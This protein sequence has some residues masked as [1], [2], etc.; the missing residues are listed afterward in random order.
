MKFTVGFEETSYCINGSDLL[1]VVITSD[2]AADSTHQ[3][4][5]QL[6]LSSTHGS[7]SNVWSNVL[8]PNGS[9]T[10]TIPYV[11]PLAWANDARVVDMNGD[12]G[13]I[14]ATLSVVYVLTISPKQYTLNYSGYYGN[15]PATVDAS[16][17]PSVGTLSYTT[18]DGKVPESWDCLVQ[19]V[20][21]VR[22]SAPQAAGAYGSDIYY[23]YFNGGTAQMQNYADISLPTA[24]DVSVSV[25]VEDSRGRLSTADLYLSV[26]A[27]QTPSLTQVSSQRCSQDGTLAEEGEYYLA[28]GT[29]AGATLSGLNPITVTT[30]WKKVTE[31]SY[32]TALTI[33]PGQDAIVVANL[34]EGASYD[35]KYTIQDAF[36]TIELYDYLSSTV[37]LLHFLKGGSGIAVG[38]AAEQESL[39]DVALNTTMRRDLVVGGNVSIT[40]E[41]QLGSIAVKES[42]QSIQTPTETQFSVNTDDFPLSDVSV[43]RIVRSGRVVLYSF[44]GVIA[45]DEPPLAGQVYVVGALPSGYYGTACL[46][47]FSGMLNDENPCAVTVSDIGQVSVSLS[48]SA[49]QRVSITGIGMLLD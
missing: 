5:F 30:A 31:E 17:L 1:H 33:T 12:N 37:Y 25:T 42:L 27:Y 39:F 35:I 38:K 21:V 3:F 34:E 6:T 11:V 29:L 24:G 22:V 26:Q 20:S 36:Y 2:T 32:G 18:V 23:Y 8:L 14:C 46:L 28:K 40:G 19:G 4:T 9:K 44:T 13:T 47:Q 7:Y 10:V 41:L 16:I 43:N 45:G 15:L 48:Q 49:Q